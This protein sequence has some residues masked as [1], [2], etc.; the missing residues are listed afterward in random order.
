MARNQAVYL[1]AYLPE[2]DA[3]ELSL[4]F[5]WKVCK[6]KESLI[7][8]LKGGAIFL[9]LFSHNQHC[10]DF[11]FVK[12]K[13]ANLKSQVSNL[14]TKKFGCQGTF[15]KKRESILF[16]FQRQQFQI[17]ESQALGCLSMKQLQKIHFTM[18]SS[19]LAT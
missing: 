4:K 13:V 19:F 11:A 8:F 7:D 1:S 9:F 15:F 10:S 3:E 18:T 17:M 12:K 5:S 14:K 16:F 2:T 6:G